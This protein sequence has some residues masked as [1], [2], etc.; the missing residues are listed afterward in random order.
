VTSVV[1]LLVAMAEDDRRRHAAAPSAAF[2]LCGRPVVAEVDHGCDANH[3][4]SCAVCALAV[5][6]DSPP[7]E[8]P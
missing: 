3:P 5:V 7:R 8:R 1:E 6:L 4:E 2:S